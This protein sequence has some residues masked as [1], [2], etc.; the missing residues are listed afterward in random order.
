MHA[1]FLF[2][3]PETRRSDVVSVKVV[4]DVN[5]NKHRHQ[6]QVDLQGGAAVELVELVLGHPLQQR[7]EVV[8]FGQHAVVDFLDGL[9]L[10][11]KVDD[12]VFVL[13]VLEA[14]LLRNQVGGRRRHGG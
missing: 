6:P 11:F 7:G 14:E 3:P 9:L 4:E 1:K 5:E 13:V 2:D 8:V 12:I 10:R